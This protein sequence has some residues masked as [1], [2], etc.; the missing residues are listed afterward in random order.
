MKKLRALKKS[1]QNL[2][3][4]TKHIDC[5]RLIVGDDLAAMKVYSSSIEKGINTKI[6]VTDHFQLEHFIGHW[7]S[8]SPLIRSKEEMDFLLQ[9]F[10]DLN[11][12][13]SDLEPTFYKD[14]KL[15]SFNGKSRP[16][17]LLEI[18]PCFINKFYY[19]DFN[20]LVTEIEQQ[21]ISEHFVQDM[22]RMKVDKV[23]GQR[24]NW[25]IRFSDFSTLNCKELYWGAGYKKYSEVIADENVDINL[26][27]FVHNYRYIPVLQI[28]FKLKKSIEESNRT[29]FFPVS[30]THDHGHYIVDFL[31]EQNHQIVMGMIF[32][33]EEM[34]DEEIYKRIKL[35]K[36][37]IQKVYPDFSNLVEGEEY[38]YKDEFFFQKH[39][40]VEFDFSSLERE[41]LPYFLGTEYKFDMAEEKDRLGIV[42]NMLHSWVDYSQK[43]NHI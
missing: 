6:V 7:N 11:Y 4:E 21:K 40:K 13:E 27:T 41:D 12:S 38:V 2:E 33:Q 14:Q 26:R 36:R 39:E 31:K 9:N 28:R 15:K 19:F 22:I 10:P 1:S 37:A 24:G 25:S 23:E 20:Q 43:E 5:E 35:L 32:V 34:S 3:L 16:E 17:K 30:Y 29:I 8:L 42:K 18:E